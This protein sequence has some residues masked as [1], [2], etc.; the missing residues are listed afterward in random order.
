MA[1]PG[2]GSCLELPLTP[3]LPNLP[4]PVSSTSCV[5]LA[6][7]SPRGREEEEGGEPLPL[8]LRPGELCYE[9][10]SG[11]P[12]SSPRWLLVLPTGK[13][14]VSQAW[15]CLQRGF[16]LGLAGAGL[17][18]AS[19]LIADPGVCSQSGERD[20][21]CPTT[22]HCAGGWERSTAGIQARAW[23]GAYGEIQGL[24]S[25]VAACVPG[26]GISLSDGDP[27]ASRGSGS[28]TEAPRREEAT[29]WAR[30]CHVRTPK[31]DLSVSTFPWS[32]AHVGDS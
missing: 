12:G 15:L 10:H 5:Y 8:P 22:Q 25:A 2:A 21:S 6:A 28:P 9:R 13:E 3:G 30:K 29:S 32:R 7:K 17:G 31:Q 16:E 26:D 20:G 19:W 1:I 4:R 11:L 14:G 27:D 18:K 23:D 24:G